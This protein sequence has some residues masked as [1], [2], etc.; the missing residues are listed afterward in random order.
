MT[1][2][3]MYYKPTAFADYATQ[4]PRI[5]HEP[6]LDDFLAERHIVVDQSSGHTAVDGALSNLRRSRDIALRI[7]HFAALPVLVE[8]TP[9][10]S[11]IPK[12]VTESFSKIADVRAF[13]LPFAV[14]EVEIALYTYRRFLPDPGTQ[15]LRETIRS[16]LAAR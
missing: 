4:P 11:V 2:L 13:D 7:S 15:W 9:Y 14:P 8:T 10:L 3:V 12:S 5:G 6:T 1:S 16:A